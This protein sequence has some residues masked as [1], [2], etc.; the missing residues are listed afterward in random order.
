M[1][2]YPLSC[3]SLGAFFGFEGVGALGAAAE[4]ADLAVGTARLLD[5]GA[6]SALGAWEASIVA[7]E[8]GAGVGVLH[9]VFEGLEGL[10]A[11]GVPAHAD[12]LDDVGAGGGL[13]DARP[14]GALWTGDSVCDRGHLYGAM[15]LLEG[16]ARAETEVCCAQGYFPFR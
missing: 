12:A 4:A 15:S 2:L 3:S 16:W 7:V 6:A 1:A 9:A 5:G 11:A 14:T 10:Q 8:V 13:D